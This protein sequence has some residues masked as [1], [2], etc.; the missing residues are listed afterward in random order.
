MKITLIAS[1]ITLTLLCLL[2]SCDDKL[3]VQQA[4]DFSLTSWYLQKTISPNETVEIRLTLNRTGNYE[5]ARYQIGY[6]QLEGSGE[7]YDKKNARLVNR[8]MQPLNSIAGLDSI[9]PCHQVFT[10][11]YQNKSSKNAEIKFVAMDNFGQE[12]DLDIS[13]A[14][15]TENEQ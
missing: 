13:F 11:F 8:E 7:V 15:E 12:K 2:G 1:S 10:L 6:I 4:Y 3:E 5:E 9:D 14:T